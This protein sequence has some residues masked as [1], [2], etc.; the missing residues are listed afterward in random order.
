MLCEVKA[1][2]NRATTHEALMN[3]DGDNCGLALGMVEEARVG[4]ERRVRRSDWRRR[5]RPSSGAR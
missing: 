4:G 5:W 2:L 3:E 1:L